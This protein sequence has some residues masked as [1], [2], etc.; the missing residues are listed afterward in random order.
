MR[1]HIAH[2]VFTFHPERL[3]TRLSGIAQLVDP[4]LT[5][6]SLVPFCAG[7]AI[8][9]DQREAIDVGLA[10]TAYAAIFL[11]EVGKNALNTLYMGPRRGRPSLLDEY[12]L[13]NIGWICFAGAMVIG[14]FVASASIPALLLLAAFAAAIAAAYAIPPVSLARR[15]FG[16]LAVA[17]IY[18]P[19]ILLGTLLMLKGVMTVESLVVAA[20]LGVLMS[21][22][23]LVG[24]NS[25]SYVS[26]LLIVAFA[27]P[28]VWGVYVGPFRLVT[29]ICGAPFALLASSNMGRGDATRE[30]AET[31]TLATFAITGVALSAAVALL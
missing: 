31:W 17:V 11:I 18:G 13:A 7:A 30:V 21:T 12:D 29:A 26:V 1:A 6:A 20:T 16:G 8:A 28:L 3:R 24:E 5:L 10:A 14:T 25:T 2:P 23:V 22:T 27:I 19:G 9:F 4:R 15:G